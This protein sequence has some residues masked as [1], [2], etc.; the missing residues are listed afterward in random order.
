VKFLARSSAAVY[1][2]AAGVAGWAFVAADWGG[3]PWQY[4]SVVVL[5]LPA[6][7]VALPVAYV[8]GG[9]SYN[10]FSSEGM[11]GLVY[12]TMTAGTA[13]LN[14]LLLH[15]IRHPRPV[16]L[17]RPRHDEADRLRQQGNLSR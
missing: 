4:W 1:V 3:S 15:A 10:V 14:V 11:V 13:A 17:R 5:T 8:V 9:L 12:G 7:L 6:L 16:R 2:A